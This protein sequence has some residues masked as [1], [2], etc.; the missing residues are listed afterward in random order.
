MKEATP[1]L[2]CPACGSTKFR[3]EELIEVT[4]V[5]RVAVC[6]IKRFGDSYKK[7]DLSE[8]LEE[9]KPDLPRLPDYF[10][11]NSCEAIYNK[12]SDLQ[13]TELATQ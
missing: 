11:C 6:E 5:R 12:A 2:S 1:L 13:P 9:I 7:R 8:Q 10:I 3:H 4:H